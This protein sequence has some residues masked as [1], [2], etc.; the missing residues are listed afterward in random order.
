MSPVRRDGIV[1]E[2]AQEVNAAAAR[3]DEHDELGVGF[4]LGVQVQGVQRAMAV[5]IGDDG[6]S[7]AL[8]AHRHEVEP[9]LH[10]AV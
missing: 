6:V 9:P 5:L 1:E 4:R 10:D 3:P 7:G 8:V 2:A